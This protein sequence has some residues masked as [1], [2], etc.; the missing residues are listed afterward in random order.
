MKRIILMLVSVLMLLSLTACGGKH[1]NSQSPASLPTEES[2]VNT[3]ESAAPQTSQQEESAAPQFG[4]M[5]DPFQGEW[6]RTDYEEIFISGDEVNF[7]HYDLFDEG[8]VSDVFTFNF[9]F[10]EDDNLVVVNQYGQ[11]RYTLAIN[12]DGQ[13]EVYSIIEDKK[14][15][16]EKLSDS[17]EVPEKTPEPAIG[18]SEIEVMAS[19]WGYPKHINKTTTKYG[20]S[21]QWVYDKGYIYFENG[22]VTAIQEK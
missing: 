8:V 3:Q 2:S 6:D 15:V 10:D 7:V 20:K 18:M 1:G 12:D 22:I 13:L 9:G 17:T 5:L 16:C 14:E 19:T 4:D 11:P 21:E